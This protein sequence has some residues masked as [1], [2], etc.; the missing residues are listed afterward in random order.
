M[1]Q[2]CR[3]LQ[4]PGWQKRESS[5]TAALTKGSHGFTCHEGA[6]PGQGS[7][8]SYLQI[9]LDHSSEYRHEKTWHSACSN[10]EV[11]SSSAGVL[12][13][14]LQVMG[15]ELWAGHMPL[16]DLVLSSLKQ[17]DQ[18]V[19]FLKPFPPWGFCYLIPCRIADTTTYLFQ[20]KMAR[21][22]AE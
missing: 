2:R 12:G 13:A 11:G 22:L 19:W 14:A 18:A 7:P 9:L 8:G 10:G 6:H 1:R 5:S 20:I 4:K 17:K 15:M 16:E 21:P 3:S